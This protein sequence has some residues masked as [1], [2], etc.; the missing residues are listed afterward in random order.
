VA[1]RLKIG[2]TARRRWERSLI[3]AGRGSAAALKH[4][5]REEL[6]ELEGESQRLRM[7][8]EIVKSEGLLR[9]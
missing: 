3:E 5:E 2:D 1:L 8:C 9:H 7:E 6:V 4:G